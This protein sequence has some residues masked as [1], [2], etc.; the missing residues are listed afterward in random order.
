[1]EQCRNANGVSVYSRMQKPYSVYAIKNLYSLLKSSLC[2]PALA[3]FFIGNK[4]LHAYLREKIKSF[5]HNP[6][7]WLI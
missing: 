1:M 2:L 5:V 4:F 6:S 7:P 3:G